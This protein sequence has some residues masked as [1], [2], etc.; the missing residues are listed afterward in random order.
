MKGQIYAL[1]SEQGTATYET[2]LCKEHYTPEMRREV[3]RS[4]PADVPNKDAWEDVSEND[5]LR[6]T[7]CGVDI[8]GNLEPPDPDRNVGYVLSESGRAAID[9]EG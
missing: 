8:E 2:V 7:V 3:S 4:A 5:V 6:C 9:G 1:V